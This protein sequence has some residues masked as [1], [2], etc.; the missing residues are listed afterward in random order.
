[1]PATDNASRS[2]RAVATD[3]SSSAASPAA[4]T[5]PRA[6]INSRVATSRSVRTSASLT[7][8]PIAARP[9]ASEAGSCSRARYCGD[10]R[11][12]RPTRTSPP[13]QT[14]ATVDQWPVTLASPAP[15]HSPRRTT[16]AGRQARRGRPLLPVGVPVRRLPPTAPAAPHLNT[17]RLPH[18]LAW[19]S[20]ITDRAHRLLEGADRLVGPAG[21]RP[22]ALS[23]GRPVPPCLGAA[24]QARTPRPRDSLR[25]WRPTV[26]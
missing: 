25:P 14:I 8:C 15:Q 12:T 17:E 2:R 18:L 9:G 6:C 1:M 5:R 24:G 3:T 7:P 4:V 23:P 26:G 16:P 10:R 19:T 20:H 21:P 11:T 22:A 13:G